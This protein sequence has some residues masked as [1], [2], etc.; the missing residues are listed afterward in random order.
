MLEKKIPLTNWLRTYIHDTRKQ[1]MEDNPSLTADYISIKI[2][3]AKS[4]LSQIENGRLKSVKSDDL[5]NTFCIIQ[6]KDINDLYERKAVANLLDDHI[7]STTTAIE[8]DLMDEDGDILD[9]PEWMVFQHVRGYLRLAG[10]QTKDYFYKIYNSD[11]EKIQKDLAREIKYIMNYIVDSFLH[12][13]N[14][15][16]SL[17]SD[18]VSTRNLYYLLNTCINTY[19][20]SYEEY[21]L[22]PLNISDEELSVLKQKLDTDYFLKPKTKA[23]SLN[24]YSYNEF[25]DVVLHF[26]TEE[27]MTWKNKPLYLGDDPFPMLINYTTAFSNKENFVNYPDLNNATGLTEQQYLYIIKQVYTQVDALYKK[28]KSS[29]RAYDEAMEE[30]E[31]CNEKI[32]QLKTE[33][34]KFKKS[35]T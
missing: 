21:G 13:F 4:W 26:S 33:L 32:E 9:L 14:D 34:E 3:R 2:G 31:D 15:I 35:T 11:I 23:K 28:Y 17:F 7:M 10:R 22:N 20:C 29:L 8:H 5:V 16:D 25:D 30:I 18:E 19:D 6:G 1:A 27:F 12:A 24:D